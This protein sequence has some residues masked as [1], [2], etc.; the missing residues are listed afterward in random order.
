M[1]GR[2]L[3]RTPCGVAPRA[4]FSAVWSGA[5]EAP[6]EGRIGSACRGH[7]GRRI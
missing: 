7:R 6:A 1:A 2:W 5:S 3:V 4:R